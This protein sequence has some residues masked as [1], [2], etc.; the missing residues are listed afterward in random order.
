MAMRARKALNTAPVPSPAA[1]EPAK[2]QRQT[3]YVAPSRT[4]RQ[5]VVCFVDRRTKRQLDTMA[6][7][8]GR[9]LQA[10]QLEALDLLFQAHKLP[11]I[12]VEGAAEATR[13]AS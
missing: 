1:A 7:E 12:A 6:F 8:Q 4:G 9:T 13:G 10:L 5:Q 11:R 2:P 3:S